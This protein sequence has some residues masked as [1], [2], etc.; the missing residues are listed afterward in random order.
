MQIACIQDLGAFVA[1]TFVRASVKIA[2]F[3]ARIRFKIE[4][5]TLQQSAV[6]YNSTLQLPAT[7][8]NTWEPD[9]LLKC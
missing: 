8:C 6:V 3:A 7:L 9:V 5:L 1:H 4:V 2:H